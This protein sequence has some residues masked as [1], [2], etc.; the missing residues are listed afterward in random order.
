MSIQLRTDIVRAL[1]AACEQVKG[2]GGSDPEF[3]DVM[4]RFVDGALRFLEQDRDIWEAR[5]AVLERLESAAL[6][7]GRD[8][9]GPY[10]GRSKRAIETAWAYAV[11]AIKELQAQ[12]MRNGRVNAAGDRVGLG[13]AGAAIQ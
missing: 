12:I 2:A 4:M 6:L 5:R 13:K 7:I 10:D 3:V 11:Q 1:A 9:T 8:R